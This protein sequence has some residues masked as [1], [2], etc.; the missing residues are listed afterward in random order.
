VPPP[1][2]RLPEIRLVLL[3]AVDQYRADY[4]T[5]FWNEYTGG[6]KHLAERGAVFT[7]AHLEH[8]PTVTAIGHATMLT[9]ATPR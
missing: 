5:R 7:N 8:Y 6:I 2:P 4:L 9:G 1:A 3:I